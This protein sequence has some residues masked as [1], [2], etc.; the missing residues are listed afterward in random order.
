MAAVANAIRRSRAGL[1]DPNRPIGSFLFLGP[2]GV[3]KTE[4]ARTLAEFLFDDERAMVR[5]DMSEYMEKHSVV[6]PRR[7]PPGLRRLRRGR[8]ADRGRAPAA[9]LRRAP[10]RDREGPPRRVQH[11]A[12]GPRR[13]PPHRRPGSHRRLHQRRARHDLEPPGRAG[14]PLPA[15]VREPHRRDRPLPVAHRGRPRPDRRASSSGTSGSGW[16]SA[17]SASRS[18][19][20]PGRCWPAGYDPDFGARPLRRVIQR[21]VA[22]PLAIALLDGRVA[23]GDAVRVDDVEGEIVVSPLWRCRSVRSPQSRLVRRPVNPLR[24]RAR[25]CND[26]RRNPVG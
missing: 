26:H 21:S 13:R 12:A 5:I 20:R 6:A 3:G 24:R 9:L 11:A 8:P 19:P 18:R 4:L 2:T 16:P 14:R 15:R 7:R 23:D 10:R 17:A 25:A 1:S 22:D